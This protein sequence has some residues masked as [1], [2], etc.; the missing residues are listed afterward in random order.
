[1]RAR[2]AASAGA[3]LRPSPCS[4]GSSHGGTN[5]KACLL[6]HT[7]QNLSL[8]WFLWPLPWASPPSASHDVLVF[9]PCLASALLPATPWDSEVRAALGSSLSH[10]PQHLVSSSSHTCKNT[11]ACVYIFPQSSSFSLSKNGEDV[12]M[13]FSQALPG[14]SA[15]GSKAPGMRR[16]KSLWRWQQLGPNDQMAALPATHARHCCGLPWKLPGLASPCPSETACQP[17]PPGEQSKGET[18]GPG[19]GTGRLPPACS[20][21][22]P[23]H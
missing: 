13:S 9:C 23:R 15:V 4:R 20:G 8:I 3:P 6:G 17:A 10:C 14:I 22:S 2:C 1:M 21:L 7:G 16:R 19:P 18:Q 12:R 5:L 11:H